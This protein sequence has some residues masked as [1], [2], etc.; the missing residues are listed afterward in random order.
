MIEVVQK[1][2]ATGLKRDDLFCLV[3]IQLFGVSMNDTAMFVAGSLMPIKRQRIMLPCSSALV[4]LLPPNT[5]SR[6]PTA[7]KPKLNL[8]CGGDPFVS[9]V[10]S[11][12]LL[13][14]TSNS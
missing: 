7:A 1:P 10:R 12:H 14:V 2:C 6:P 13:F 3:R 4:W 11:L 9:A 8:A 5:Y